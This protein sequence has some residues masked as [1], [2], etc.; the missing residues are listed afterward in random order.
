MR[1]VPLGKWDGTF[2]LEPIAALSQL[3]WL[4]RHCG[5]KPNSVSMV[6]EAAALGVQRS[7]GFYVGLMPYT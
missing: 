5:G 3:P 4:C 2:N 6:G 1:N 7:D